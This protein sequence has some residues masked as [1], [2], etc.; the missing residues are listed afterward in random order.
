MDAERPPDNQRRRKL[1]IAATSA[2]GGA[3]MVAS[4]VP[5]V[6]SMLPSERAK[7][8]GAPVTFLPQAGAAAAGPDW[9]GAC[10]EACRPRPTW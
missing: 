3:G 6:A 1:L 2:T 4:A 8:V 7:A 9:P 5:F 10:S